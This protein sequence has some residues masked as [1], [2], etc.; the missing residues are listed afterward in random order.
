[1]LNTTVNL[2]RK[3]PDTN[4]YAL[5]HQ[6]LRLGLTQKYRYC[7]ERAAANYRIDLRELP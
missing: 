5:Q 7:V 1:M 4:E 6:W 2:W 3:L